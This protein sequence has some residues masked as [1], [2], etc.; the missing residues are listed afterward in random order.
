MKEL[1][2][3]FGATFLAL[4][5]CGDRAPI[6]DKPVGQTATVV[7]LRAA[8]ALVDPP[9][10]RAVLLVGG[11]DQSL[12]RISVPVGH[13]VQRVEVSPDKR[14]LFVLAAGDVPRRSEKDELP[15]L[16]VVDQEQTGG[17]KSRRYALATP[18]SGLSVDPLGRWAC[19]YAGTPSQ[20]GAS[21]ALPFVENPN[22]IVLVDLN[23]DPGQDNPIPRTLRSFGGKPQRF[24]FTA[25]LQLPAGPRRLLLVES[26]QD[27]NIL[28]LDHMTDAD[29]YPEVTVRLTSGASSRQ[30]PPAGLVVDDGDAGNGEDARI[31]IRTANDRNVFVVQLAA[32]PPEAGRTIKTDF[33]PIVNMADVGGVPSDLAFVRTDGG[34]R[35]A[36]I[37]PATYSAVLVEPST[38]V[39]SDPIKLAQ[40]YQRISLVT[41][42]VGEP[43]GGSGPNATVALLWNA[44]GSTSGGLA[45]WALGKTT[46]QPYRSVEV[47]GLSGTV[48]SL[49]DVPESNTELKI[50]DASGGSAAFYVLNLKSRTASPLVSTGK[51]SLYVSPD[52]NRVWAYQ[53][54]TNKLASIDLKTLHPVPL[55][56]EGPIHSVYD[57]ERPA[58][59]RSLVAVH[60]DGKGSLAATVLDALAPDTA[61]ARHHSGLLLE[62]L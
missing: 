21:S 47:V 16:T 51:P 59:G 22:E 41:E 50:L 12:E 39:T 26:E 54:G 48:A 11:P 52:G 60:N 10:N 42:L 46:G 7:G 32:A 5:G 8:V 18:A 25:P 43:P 44:G 15:S 13:N 31:G 53:P 57:I 62:G 20:A 17:F 33:K 49:L 45:F 30:L 4:A 1:A 55:V 2:L 37:V 56:V 28:D 9:A 40:P 61:L 27:V 6:W 14:R 3:V 24:T 36:A 29:G 19:V 35:L 34:V 38:M 58:G 23:R